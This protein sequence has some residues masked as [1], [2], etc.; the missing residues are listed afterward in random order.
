MAQEEEADSLK[1]TAPKQ[2][3]IYTT[4]EAYRE[5][6]PGPSQ[7][8][9]WRNPTD[10]PMRARFFVGPR[11]ADPRSRREMLTWTGFYTVTID[12]GSTLCLPV[13]WLV[14]VV[15]GGR[16]VSGRLP[17]AQRV[18]DPTSGRPD[19]VTFPELHPSLDDSRATPARRRRKAAA[20]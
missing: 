16:V 17:R 9:F 14:Q 20:E 18:E 1:R 15:Q 3:R 2:D 11:D 13:E 6:R 4:H 19:P 5:Q 8:V 10:A 12:P 7:G